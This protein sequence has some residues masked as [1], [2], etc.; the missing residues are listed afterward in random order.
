M[1]EGEASSSGVELFSFWRISPMPALPAVLNHSERLAL[2]RK[3]RAP[4]THGHA[5]ER[6]PESGL[7]LARARE[8]EG[9]TRAR[10]DSTSDLG[11]EEAREGGEFPLFAFLLSTFPFLVLVDV[12]AHS[13]R[14][15]PLDVG[16][17]KG[18][19]A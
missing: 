2:E 7:R 8:C 3:P 18:R 17:R 16:R 11:M 13:L 12:V 4:R 9:T 19:R 6:G 15:I 10:V 14:S 1:G 5:P